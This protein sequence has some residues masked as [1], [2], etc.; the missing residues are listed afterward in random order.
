[1]EASRNQGNAGRVRSG[2]VIGGGGGSGGAGA[3][4]E[5]TRERD[6]QGAGT[7]TSVNPTRAAAARPTQANQGLYPVLPR[8][9]AIL[10]AGADV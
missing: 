10:C 4:S 3:V 8:F 1:M 2:I 6:T 9:V 7:S 5:V